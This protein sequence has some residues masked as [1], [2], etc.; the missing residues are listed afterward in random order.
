MKE[1]EDEQLQATVSERGAK[2]M[3]GGGARGECEGGTAGLPPRQ[4]M[5]ATAAGQTQGAKQ[6]RRASGSTRGCT[7]EA[8]VE[9]GVGM[10]AR[11]PKLG[12]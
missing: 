3:G 8:R 9:E 12:L 5:L 11:Q 7:A 10:G 4:K 1:Q 6:G 2:P